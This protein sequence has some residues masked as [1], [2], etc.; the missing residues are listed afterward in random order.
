[1]KTVLPTRTRHPRLFFISSTSTSVT[2][3]TTTVC[4]Y[5]GTVAVTSCTGKRKRAI[6]DLP[7]HPG[8]IAL[9]IAPKRV[10]REPVLDTA[11]DLVSGMMEEERKERVLVYWDTTTT[12]YTTTTYYDTSTIATVECTPAAF[13]I[14]VCG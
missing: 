14:S 5:S 1:M 8:D 10:Q 9:Q 6:L 7:D 2:F 4:F 11:D 12:T 3:S 13:T